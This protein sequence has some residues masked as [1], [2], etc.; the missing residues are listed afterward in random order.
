MQKKKDEHSKKLQA[1]QVG[2]VVGSFVAVFMASFL[3]NALGG[4][5]TIFPLPPPQPVSIMFPST[6]E[7]VPFHPAVVQAATSR[8]NQ[9]RKNVISAQLNA[10]TSEVHDF[11]GPL[12]IDFKHFFSSEERAYLLEVAC[13]SISQLVPADVSI[14]ECRRVCLF[15]WMIFR[16]SRPI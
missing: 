16:A 9:Q 3:F 7:H 15:H 11:N 1:L 6:P 8:V 10:H 13:R 4:F 2:F 14:L 5:E 12:Y